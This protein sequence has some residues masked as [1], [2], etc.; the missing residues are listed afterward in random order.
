MFNV[1]QTAGIVEVSV[2]A[3]YPSGVHPLAQPRSEGNGE[4]PTGRLVTTETSGPAPR[5]GTA[6]APRLP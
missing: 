3:W 4:K 2:T 5:A 1:G 6:P